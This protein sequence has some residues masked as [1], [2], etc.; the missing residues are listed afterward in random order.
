MGGTDGQDPRGA[1]D[2]TPLWNV[3]DLTPGGRGIDWYP[4]VDDSADAWKAA[5]A[6]R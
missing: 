1:P 5:P 4:D 2:P 3:L 6:N